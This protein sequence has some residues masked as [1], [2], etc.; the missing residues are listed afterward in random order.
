MSQSQFSNEVEYGANPQSSIRSSPF[1]DTGYKQRLPVVFN[2]VH[3]TSNTVPDTLGH[4]YGY[5]R[6]YKELIRS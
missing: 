2:Q 1:R 6:R 4:F 3:I 5:F